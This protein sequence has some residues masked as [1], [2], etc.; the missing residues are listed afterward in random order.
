MTRM[1][2]KVADKVIAPPQPKVCCRARTYAIAKPISVAKPHKVAVNKHKS[3]FEALKSA[4]LSNIAIFEALNCSK[5]NLN[6]M[7]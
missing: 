4:I 2:K 3:Q 1:S 5:A 6:F 7:G